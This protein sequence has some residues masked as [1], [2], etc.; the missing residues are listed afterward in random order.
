[1][2]PFLVLFGISSELVRRTESLRQKNHWLVTKRVF[3]ER[4]CDQLNDSFV[5]LTQCDEQISTKLQK[6]PK[7]KT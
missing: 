4:F 5:T 1:M 2:S 3:F 7:E 6:M